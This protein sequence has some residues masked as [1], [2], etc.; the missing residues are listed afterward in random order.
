MACLLHPET[1]IGPSSVGLLGHV[2]IDARRTLLF[3]QTSGTCAL[4]AEA[5][6]LGHYLFKGTLDSGVHL[7]DGVSIIDTGNSC[8]LRFLHTK[9]EKAPYTWKSE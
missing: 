6:D 1:R 8:S 4:P 9:P 7:Q 3:F 5:V 2:P